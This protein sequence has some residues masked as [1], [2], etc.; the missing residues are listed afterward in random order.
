MNKTK[1][2]MNEQLAQAKILPLLVRLAIPA[3]AAQLVNAL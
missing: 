2:A 1:D 3:A